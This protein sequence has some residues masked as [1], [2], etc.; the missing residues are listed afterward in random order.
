MKRNEFVAAAIVGLLALPLLN[1]F[2]AI[3]LD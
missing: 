2:V 3:L 1:I